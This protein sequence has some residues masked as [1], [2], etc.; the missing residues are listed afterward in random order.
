M[1]KLVIMQTKAIGLVSGGLDSMIAT[2]LMIEQNIDVLLIMFASPF[3]HARLRDKEVIFLMDRKVSIIWLGNNYFN[4]IKNPKYGYGAGANPC[5]D[6]KIFML[7]FAAEIMREEKASFIFTGEVLNQRPFSQTRNFMLMIEKE[8][9]LKGKIL[10]PLSAKLLEPTIPE[11]SGLVKREK[12]LDISGRSRKKQILIASQMKITGYSQ[13]AG[14]CLLTD[15]IY[16]QKIIEL[17]KKWPDSVSDDAELIKYGR[18][19]WHNTNLIVIGRNELDN[20]VLLSLRKMEDIA[21]YLHNVPGPVCI[22]RGK[23]ISVETIDYAKRLILSYSKK[24]N[25]RAI[26]WIIL[27]GTSHD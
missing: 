25:D 8:T 7:K 3:F 4:I 5:I 11:I 19:F 24:V 27:R 2:K 18:T 12:L 9:G 21:I 13:P 20:R 6:C 15:K 14:G 17:I 16:S 22:I 1:I 23:M 26:E 10:R